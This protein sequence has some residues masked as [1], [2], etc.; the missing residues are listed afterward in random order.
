MSTLL[1]LVSRGRWPRCRR[2]K[3]E[4]PRRG[5]EASNL[6]C[7]FL[8]LLRPFSP[9]PSPLSSLF[10]LPPREHLLAAVW[11]MLLRPLP[12]WPRVHR[13]AKYTTAIAH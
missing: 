2:S 12:V 8:R 13:V 3:G 7:T 9:R 6:I 1:G 11:E 5:S 10:V 4:T